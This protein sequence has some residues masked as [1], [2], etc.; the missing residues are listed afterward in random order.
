VSGI[1]ASVREGCH[2][3]NGTPA[4]LASAMI[5]KLQT[6]AAKQ[7]PTYCRAP[8][9]DDHADPRRARYPLNVGRDTTDEAVV[10][11]TDDDVVAGGHEHLFLLRVW[12]ALVTSPWVTDFGGVGARETFGPRTSGLSREGCPTGQC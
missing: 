8:A 2:D 1:F 9:T 12:A 4:R 3:V 10:S 7:M 11:G 5:T 6:Q